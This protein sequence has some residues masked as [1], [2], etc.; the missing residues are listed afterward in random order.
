LQEIIKISKADLQL[1]VYKYNDLGLG[2][3]DFNK[4]S[5]GL[6]PKY[7]YYSFKKKEIVEGNEVDTIKDGDK[8]V[9][10][11]KSDK[12]PCVLVPFILSDDKIAGRNFRVFIN[13]L[14]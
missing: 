14:L 3:F 9:S 4:A 11:L 8:F 13:L 12:S 5:T 10:I 6:I 1:P 2:L 7:Q